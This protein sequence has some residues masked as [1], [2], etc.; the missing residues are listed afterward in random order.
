MRR[1]H[2]IVNELQVIAAAGL[3]K[4]G[5][6]LALH[7]ARTVIVDNLLL[8]LVGARCRGENMRINHHIAVT[9]LVEVGV[10]KIEMLFP[11]GHAVATSRRVQL[12]V[13]LLPL[14]GIE[15][16]RSG[17]EA[18]V[19]RGFFRKLHADRIHLQRVRRKRRHKR[20]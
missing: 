15:K 12:V 20:E 9:R 17:R 16:A 3:V 13:A 1:H 6:L 7:L 8:Q 10:R 2:G 19:V 4:L 5:R 11:V 14:V 18:V